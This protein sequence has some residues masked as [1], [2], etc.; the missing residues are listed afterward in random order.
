MSAIVTAPTVKAPTV[1]APVRADVAIVGGGVAALSAAV[2]LKKAGLSVVLLEKRLCGAGASGVNFGGVRQQGREFVELPLSARSRK[3]WDGLSKFLGED[4]EFEATGH[5]KLARSEADLAELERYAETAREW[6]LDLTMLGPNAV[7]DALPWLGE[8]V[9]GASLSPTDGQAN[10]RLVGPAY[11]RLARRLGVDVRE[12]TPVTGATRTADGFVVEAAGVTVHARFLIN[13]AGAGGGLVASAFGEPVPVSPLMPNMLVTEPLP[14]FV[15][16]SIGVVG[17]DVYV[18]QIRRGNVIFGGGSGWRDAA[19]DLARPVTEQ[20]LGGMA[21][22]LHLVPGLV[23]A[24]VIRSWSGIDGQM[25]DHIPVVGPSSTTPG[26]VHAFGFS[27]HGFQL[28]PAIGMILAELVL[29][30]RTESPIAPFAITRFKDW[31]GG[32]GEAVTHVEH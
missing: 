30:G 6:G 16:R 2:T 25:P 19:T 22:T 23:E 8:R 5:I 10:P 12:H 28:G 21:R 29:D 20:S 4:V 27:G 11:A 9:V 15:E 26:L 31:A 24:Q 14:Y 7:H 3:L 18:R 1:T 13:A 32:P 17:G